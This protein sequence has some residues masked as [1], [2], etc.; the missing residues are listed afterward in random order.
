[1]LNPTRKAKMLTLSALA[2]QILAIPN[3][4]F[5]TYAVSLPFSVASAQYG[6]SQAEYNHLFVPD[7]AN[8]DGICGPDQAPTLTTSSS[9][10]V[11]SNIN[12]FVAW[13]QTLA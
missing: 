2:T 3:F 8:I 7:F 13:I 6:I 5:G 1:M 9:T 4:N 11:A 10:K 12:K